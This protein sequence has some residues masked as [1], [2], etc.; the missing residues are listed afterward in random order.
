VPTGEYTMNT[1]SEVM[2]F[3]NDY[4]VIGLR[5]HIKKLL[6]DKIQSTKDALEILNTSMIGILIDIASEYMWKRIQNETSE[7]YIK[8]DEINQ[9][10]RERLLQYILQKGKVIP[11][12]EEV[13]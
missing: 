3:A 1:L 4:C 6:T 7:G 5:D 12:F 9:L 10:G 13:D 2:N 11:T 8:F